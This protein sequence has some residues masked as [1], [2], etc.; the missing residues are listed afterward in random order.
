MSDDYMLNYG[1]LIERGKI[2]AMDSNGAYTVE[3]IDRPNVTTPALAYLFGTSGTIPA[4][5]DRVYFFMFADGSGRVIC[6][7]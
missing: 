4:I 5:G 7:I 3:S 2:K 1:A 6:K